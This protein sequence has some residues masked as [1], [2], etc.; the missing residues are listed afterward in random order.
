MSS[1][2]VTGT[3]TS[4]KL[5][6]VSEERRRLSA[7]AGRLGLRRC[8]TRC[9]RSA[10]VLRCRSGEHVAGRHGAARRRS[11]ARA[12]RAGHR[13]YVDHSGPASK[14]TSPGSSRGSGF[15]MTISATDSQARQARRRSLNLDFRQPPH[16]R[17]S[18][19]PPPWP[20]PRR[21]NPLARL[22]LAERPQRRTCRVIDVSQSGRRY[23]HRGR[24]PLPLGTIVTLGTVQGRVVRHL[25]DGFA[26]EFTR[27]QHPDSLEENITGG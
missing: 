12:G 25:E 8:I 1:R 13:F 20:R 23:R 4:T 17:S 10:R 18:G 16:P 3:E 9:S 14:A 26:I 7:G 24:R 21:A 15:A 6:A 22:I 19:R 11:A 5:R 2:S 27:L